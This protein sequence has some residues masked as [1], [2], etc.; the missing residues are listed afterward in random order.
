[1]PLRRHLRSTSADGARAVVEVLFH[2]LIVLLEAGVDELGAVLLDVGRG[3]CDRVGTVMPSL[4]ARSGVTSSDLPLGILVVRIPHQGLHLD[5]IDHAL[6]VV[7]RADR[8]LHR[9]RARAEALL[10]HVHAA[11]EARA[12]AVHLVD[13]AHARHVVVV[14]EAPVGFRL[15]LHAG[16][17]VEH[18]D[19]AVEHAQRA[20][21]LDGEVD[22]PGGVDEVDLLVAPEGRHR[23]A[24]DGDAALLFLLE[25]VRGRRRL[26]ILG[27]VDVDDRVLAPRVIQ[28]ALGRRR[29]AGI[30]VGDDA[31]V[32]DVRKRGSTGHSKFP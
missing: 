23:G 25:V 21:H 8:D 27:V 18:H 16:H 19:R 3:S 14:R 32:A 29:L 4:S 20:V 2:R 30:D 26:Q 9:Q 15:R 13:V 10:D 1:M 7:F 5:Q 31:D 12:A 6:E 24:L 22:V 28:D 11:H 17:A